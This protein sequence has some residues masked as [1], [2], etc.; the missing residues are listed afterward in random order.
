MLSIILSVAI[1][2]VTCGSVRGVL[3]RVGAFFDD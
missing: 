1:L 2:I 3:A